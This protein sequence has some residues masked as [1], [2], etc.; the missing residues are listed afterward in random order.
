MPPNPPSNTLAPVRL[1]LDFYDA[2]LERYVQ[3][4]QRRAWSRADLEAFRRLTTSPSKNAKIPS[5]FQTKIWDIADLVFNWC[6]ELGRCA[7]CDRQGKTNISIQFSVEEPKL[8]TDLWVLKSSCTIFCPQ[9]F[10]LQEYLWKPA[11]LA[12]NPAMKRLVRVPPSPRNLWTL[13]CSP[14]ST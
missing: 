11:D 4:E 8:D 7:V 13:P 10:P 2:P 12:P 1:I 14:R 3:L 5:N 6:D 9:C